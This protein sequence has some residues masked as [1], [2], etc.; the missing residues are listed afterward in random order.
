[1]QN[2]CP[3]SA[4]V[5]GSNWKEPV[6]LAGRGFLGPWIPGVPGTLGVRADIVASLVIMGML[7]HVGVKL[8][9][10][11]VGLGEELAPQVCFG[12]KFRLDA[13]M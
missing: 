10:G 13:Q 12:H 1:M 8:P 6:P 2:Q 7:E 5:T 11:V 3:R 9:L 4:P